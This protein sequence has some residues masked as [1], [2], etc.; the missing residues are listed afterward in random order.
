VT[1]F[2]RGLPREANG[3]LRGCRPARAKIV[4][5]AGLSIVHKRRIRFVLPAFLSV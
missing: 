4:Q 1:P 2:L 3:L 5:N